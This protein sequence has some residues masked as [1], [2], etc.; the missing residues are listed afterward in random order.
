MWSVVATAVFV[1]GLVKWVF[2]ALSWLFPESDE[3]T[4]IGLDN[5]VDTLDR[6]SLFE[7]GRGL[8]RKLLLPVLHLI[9]E[10][11]NIVYLSLGLIL[12]NTVTFLVCAGLMISTHFASIQGGVAATW[13]S[14][15]GAGIGNFTAMSLLVALL[16]GF[17]DLASL[18]ITVFLLLRAVRATTGWTLTKHLILDILVA[19]VACLWAYGILSLTVSTFY[20]DM[21]PQVIEWSRGNPDRFLLPTLSETLNANPR[22]WFVVIGLGLSA[23]FP[24]LIYLIVVIPFL[25]LRVLPNSLKHGIAKVIYL[26]TTDKKPV[27]VQLSNFFSSTGALLAAFIAWIKFVPPS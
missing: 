17:F 26:L 5:A 19:I 27:L 14:V 15:V 3:I 21:L 16:A 24:T 6:K 1:F 12:L 11:K 22:V 10:K 4:R 20:N 2:G 25:L 7:I 18:A 13:S 8:L 23:C 9:R